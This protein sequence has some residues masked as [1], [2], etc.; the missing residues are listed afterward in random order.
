MSTY[1]GV[2]I[3][4]FVANEL[5]TRAG[6]RRQKENLM[7]DKEGLIEKCLDELSEYSDRLGSN[8][9]AKVYTNENRKLI[10]SVRVVLDLES[11]S[12]KVKTAGAAHVAALDS[13]IF[14]K[15][16]REISSKLSDISDQ[17]LRIQFRDFLRKL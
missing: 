8:L 2:T 4:N 13:K 14:I 17:E 10:E 5:S 6:D 15:K 3:G 1:R 7:L 16:S 9:I 12:K 11:L